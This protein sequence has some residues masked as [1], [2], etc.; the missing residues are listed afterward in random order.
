[1]HIDN[2][3]RPLYATTND[4]LLGLP[5][6]SKA[7]RVRAFSPKVRTGSLF[8]AS[9][10][11]RKKC[12]EEK[13]AC[14][15]CRDSQVKCDGYAP[16]PAQKKRSPLQKAVSAKAKKRTIQ[17]TPEM[18][19]TVVKHSQPRFSI[20]GNKLNLE[21]DGSVY[22]RMFFHHFRSITMID[23]VR[24]VNPK[25]F[26]SQRVLPMC[27]DEPAVRNAVI[28][29]GAAHYVYL[30][31]LSKPYPRE[32]D[33]SMTYFECVATQY[34]NNAIGQLVTLNDANN[35][36]LWDSQL[37]ILTCC[38]LF[39][40]LENIFGRSDEGLRHMQA[41]ARLL[42][43][44]DLS[45]A[46]PNFQQL[47]QEIA[48]VLLHFC[49]DVSYLDDDFDVPNMLPYVAPLV[50]LDDRVQPF[51]S[52]AEAKDAM[53]DLDVRMTYIECPDHESGVVP[54]K[55]HYIP[56]NMNELIE[57][58]ERWKTKFNLL[59]ASQID[60]T[61]VPIEIQRETLTLMLRRAVWEVIMPIN[62]DNEAEELARLQRELV[63][64]AELLYSIESSWLDRPIFTLDSDTIPAL[65]FVG[66][67]CEDPALAQ[68][69]L[70]LLRGS[71][72]REGP[73][74]SWKVAD[75]LE[76]ELLN[77]SPCPFK[78]GSD[79]SLSCRSGSTPNSAGS[80]PSSGTPDFTSSFSVCKTE[81]L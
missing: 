51:A 31:K 40:C 22:D 13:P 68:R 2:M 75:K 73:W 35:S 21:I 36:T 23:F 69:I 7:P 16:I 10:I 41:G 24:L 29:L 3:T 55:D 20:P 57:P 70:A 42:E 44:F 49:V 43:T 39:I 71:R 5:V 74:D 14:R 67:S 28:A 66:L 15:R 50:E 25:D 77:P 9:R 12:D 53:W 33:T 52:L 19:Q 76:A 18:V 64:M 27:H 48:T 78:S 81:F 61:D 79:S 63:D 32:A 1:M 80:S 37:R 45:T 6:R 54:D 46:P 17:A 58:F 56:D 65:Y 30:Q 34:Y 8:F 11:R 4:N 38:L 60:N 72:R 47:I 62:S 59:V 26:W